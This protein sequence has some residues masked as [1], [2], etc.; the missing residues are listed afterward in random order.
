MYDERFLRI[1]QPDWAF[2]I[3]VRERF[4]D[5]FLFVNRS[6]IIERVDSKAERHIHIIVLLNQQTRL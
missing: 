2:E 3:H 1:S 5:S 6:C 4:N